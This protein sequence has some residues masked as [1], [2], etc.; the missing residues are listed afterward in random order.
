M[1]DACTLCS[2]TT[3]SGAFIARGVELLN[4]FV[5]WRTNH[6]VDLD[7]GLGIMLE[8]LSNR[9]PFDCPR[10]PRSKHG[11]HRSGS[12]ERL[13]S[14]SFSVETLFWRSCRCG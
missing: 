10:T 12:A 13:H 8:I 1:R 6:S 3:S 5:A 11:V 9:S 2:I 7:I 4:K 14:K